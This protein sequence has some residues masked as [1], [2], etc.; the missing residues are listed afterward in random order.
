M[1]SRLILELKQVLR[2]SLFHYERGTRD[3]LRTLWDSSVSIYGRENL[4]ERFVV[5]FLSY[6]IEKGIKKDV[7]MS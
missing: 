1:S 5:A 6:N 3:G 4:T 2:V 7:G